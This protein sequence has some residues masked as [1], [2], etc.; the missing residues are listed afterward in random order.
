[1]TEFR[2][3]LLADGSS[4]R[5]LLYVLEWTLRQGF[6]GLSWLQPGFGYRSKSGLESDVQRL[7]RT[8]EPHVLFV[9]RDAEG[10]ALEER[11]R[12]IPPLPLP[13]VRVVPVRMT[14]AWLLIDERAIRT[15]AG[16]PSGVVPLD[17]PALR[18]IERLPDPKSLLRRL[19]L[20][21]SGQSG[22]RRQA[23]FQRDIAQRVRRVAESIP[24]FAP[25][26]DLEAFVAF[27][28]ELL[29][30]VGSWVREQ[31]KS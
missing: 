7:A 8:F 29:R 1:M 30:V 19:L 5:A 27:E 24:D 4:D 9:H 2:F 6:S 22:R 15:A 25:L 18:R 12:E 23:Q 20:Q 16:N 21:A 28:E 17:I 26:R 14:E 3:A 13:C 10:V 31:S 11:R